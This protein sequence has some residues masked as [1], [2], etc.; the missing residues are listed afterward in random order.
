[1]QVAPIEREEIG[2][3]A[4]VGGEAGL[5]AVRTTILSSARTGTPAAPWLLADSVAAQA[6]AAVFVALA[7]TSAY[8][9]RLQGR[10]TA[11]LRGIEQLLI[12]AAQLGAAVGVAT[13]AGASAVLAA[14]GLAVGIPAALRALTAQAQRCE[15]Q[16]A[17]QLRRGEHFLTQPRRAVTIERAG[18]EGRTGAVKAA[19]ATAPCQTVTT[20]TVPIQLAADAF[21]AACDR[22]AHA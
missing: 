13:T 6:I 3:C 9:R 2:P 18:A 4:Q 11:A 21:A 16:R 8:A 17:V 20:R 12:A 10:R 1:L 22:A 15:A 7:Q 14:A 5:A 19:A